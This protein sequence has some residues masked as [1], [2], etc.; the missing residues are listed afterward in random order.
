MS[1]AYVRLWRLP[2]S[3]KETDRILRLRFERLL[4]RSIHA[5]VFRHRY[6]TVVRGHWRGR[7]GLGK[8]GDSL[9]SFVRMR[10]SIVFW[11]NFERIDLPGGAVCQAVD[12]HTVNTLDICTFTQ[13]TIISSCMVD[14]SDVLEVPVVCLTIRA[15]RHRSH[16]AV[17]SLRLKSSTRNASW[18]CCGDDG[19]KP[20]RRAKDG[21]SCH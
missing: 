19:P 9:H 12:S 11:Q 8:V 14:R 18:S 5:A 10:A 21:V 2:I 17:R 4:T 3:R 20:W 7:R 13:G 1:Y 6:G 16:V 15:A